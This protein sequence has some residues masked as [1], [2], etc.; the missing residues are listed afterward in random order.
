MR[1]VLLVLI[2]VVEPQRERLQAEANR[3]GL[4]C[5]FAI[6][7]ASRAEA[8]RESGPRV[9]VVLTNGSTGDT[10]ALASASGEL[11]GAGRDVYESEPAAPAALMG[12]KNVVLR[13]HEAGWSP[14]AL[15][16]CYSLFLD[17]LRL[18]LAGAA[19]RSPV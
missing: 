3:F 9:R 14:E 7:P 8:M 12:L 2:H 15:A 10:A 17:N 16:A 18:H 13:P 1:L 19:V 4:G 6:D 11:A 5:Q